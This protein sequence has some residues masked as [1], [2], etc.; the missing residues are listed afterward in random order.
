MKHILFVCYGN[1]M[2]SQIA[3][4]YY[5][6]L[7]HSDRSTSAATSSHTEGVYT[8][9]AEEVITVMREEGIDV[10]KQPV[11]HITKA[12]VDTADQIYVFTSRGDCPDFLADSSKAIFWPVAD[13]WGT[14]LENFRHTRDIIKEKITTLVATENR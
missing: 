6:H 13:P 5:N 1:I 4:G 10:S 9:P 12:M 3:Q 11:R 2:R 7:T 8:S 14:S